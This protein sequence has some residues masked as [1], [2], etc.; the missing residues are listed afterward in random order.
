M[1]PVF[2]ISMFICLTS[3][4]A[5]F[6]P[7]SISMRLWKKGKN[8]LERKKS[9]NKKKNLLFSKGVVLRVKKWE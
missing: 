1:K 9:K 4:V 2:T 6:L 3:G 5:G 8:I 7:D